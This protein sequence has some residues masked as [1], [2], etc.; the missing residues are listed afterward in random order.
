MSFC[1]GVPLWTIKMQ[2]SI[3]A[4]LICAKIEIRISLVSGHAISLNLHSYYSALA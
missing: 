4:L 1:H 3:F 2:I